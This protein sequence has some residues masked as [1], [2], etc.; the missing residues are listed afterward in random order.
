[1][2]VCSCNYIDTA[3]IKAVLNYATE[4]NEQQ[5]LNMLAWTPQCSYCKE[6]ITN[7]IRKCIKEMCH[8]G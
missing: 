7:E 2:I 1:M 8:G 5:V 6:M 3:D 4:P